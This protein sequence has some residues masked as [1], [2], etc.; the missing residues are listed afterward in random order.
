MSRSF[1]N[2]PGRYY[3]TGDKIVTA[4]YPGCP[5]AIFA[6][7]LAADAPLHLLAETE[8]DFLDED[9]QGAGGVR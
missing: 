5:F 2:Y 4:H 7:G 1:H 6:G 8:R 9:D 3:S